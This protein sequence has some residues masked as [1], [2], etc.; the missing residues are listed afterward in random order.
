MT[1][2]V[3]VTLSS[4]SRPQVDSQFRQSHKQGFAISCGLRLCTKVEWGPQIGI[5][6]Q[7]RPLAMLYCQIRLLA[8]LLGWVRSQA[9]ELSEVEDCALWFYGVAILALWISGTSGYV[10][11][12]DEIT[13]WVP[14][15]G[16]VVGWPL[17]WTVPLVRF[18]GC[19]RS[20]FRLSGYV[21]TGTMINSKAGVLCWLSA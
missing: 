19:P 2:T 13:G 21:G 15:Q 5:H 18:R 8:R 10:P 20:V 16:R 11:S 1:L 9:V 17:W 3:P 12:L 14:P 6:H 4:Q 7:V